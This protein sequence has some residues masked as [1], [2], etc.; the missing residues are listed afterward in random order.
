[1]SNE[2]SRISTSV[3]PV[4]SSIYSWSISLAG[5]AYLSVITVG[6]AWSLILVKV[7]IT[8]QVMELK[9]QR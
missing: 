7:R 5:R 6:L 2:I 3:S 9:K 4:E 8:I 1:M